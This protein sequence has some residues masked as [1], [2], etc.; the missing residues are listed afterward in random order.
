MPLSE[1]TATLSTVPVCG[2]EFEKDDGAEEVEEEFEEEDGV[3]KERRLT[4][5]SHWRRRWRRRYPTNDEGAVKRMEF[6]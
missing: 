5:S 1:K 3:G 6:E 4:A 2:S